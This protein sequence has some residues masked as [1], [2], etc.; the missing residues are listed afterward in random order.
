[1]VGRIAIERTPIDAATTTFSIRPTADFH[2][3]VSARHVVEPSAIDAA[4]FRVNRRVAFG[5]LFG[6]RGWTYGKQT[7]RSSEEQSLKTLHDPNYS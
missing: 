7:G 4:I 6:G 1:M 5:G 3:K 2:A